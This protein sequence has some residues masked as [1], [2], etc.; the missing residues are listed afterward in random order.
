MNREQV[1]HRHVLLDTREAGHDVTPQT[2]AEG[3]RQKT[4]AEK[5]VVHE[6]V[7]Y[8][9]HY[10]LERGSFRAKGVLRGDGKKSLTKSTTETEAVQEK[11]AVDKI[12]RASSQVKRSVATSDLQ[13]KGKEDRSTESS[14]E[15]VK[16]FETAGLAEQ[17][18]L[19]LCLRGLSNLGKDGLEAHSL[20]LELLEVGRVATKG[21]VVVLLAKDLGAADLSIGRREGKVLCSTCEELLALKESLLVSLH[22]VVGV[23]SVPKTLGSLLKVRAEEPETTLEHVECLLVAGACARHGCNNHETEHEEGLAHILLDV[24]LVH[25]LE[26]SVERALELVRLDV[27]LLALGLERCLSISLDVVGG[28]C[29][30][31]LATLYQRLAQANSALDSSVYTRY[32]SNGDKDKQEGETCQ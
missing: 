19:L 26:H 14:V 28:L 15:S 5:R 9:D 18:G 11:V 25:V 21:L 2:T 29:A 7:E 27:E 8:G 23:H 12:R 30:L 4:K 32:Q 10:G 22:T 17:S 1:I 13:R 16:E 3:E 31:L 24:K 6:A 20:G